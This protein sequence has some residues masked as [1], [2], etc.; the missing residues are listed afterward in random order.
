MGKKGKRKEG[1]TR[2]REGKQ[3]EKEWRRPLPS[4]I[5]ALVQTKS[6]WSCGKSPCRSP[7]SDRISV[8]RGPPTIDTNN[9]LDK[10]EFEGKRDGGEKEERRMRRMAKRIN[11]QKKE[12]RRPVVGVGRQP[13]PA[14]MP[15]KTD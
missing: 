4:D 9:K 2:K 1:K 13:A 3:E 5:L 6:D 15:T 12:L 8:S 10:G 7:R 14:D 11:Q